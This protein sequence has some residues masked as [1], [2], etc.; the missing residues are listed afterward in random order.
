VIQGE[1]PTSDS[2]WSSLLPTDMAQVMAAGET[3]Y[4]AL[5]VHALRWPPVCCHNDLVVG[6]MVRGNLGS[7][8][9]KLYLIDFEYA[10]C[11]DRYQH[12]IC[13][14]VATHD[15]II[16]DVIDLCFLFVVTCLQII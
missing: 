15:M 10:A 11:G 4:Q 2:T 7:N 14:Q 8:E 9:R 1:N 16:V 12:I 13:D 6:N 5:Q 3:I